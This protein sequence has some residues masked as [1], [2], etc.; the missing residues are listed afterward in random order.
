MVIALR[1]VG[2]QDSAIR[3][4]LATGLVALAVPN[5]TSGV[6]P[7]GSAPGPGGAIITRGKTRAR[8]DHRRITGIDDMTRSDSSLVRASDELRLDSEAA[9]MTGRPA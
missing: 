3:A 8:K 2:R 5:L 4:A 6:D 1:V 9:G 7:G